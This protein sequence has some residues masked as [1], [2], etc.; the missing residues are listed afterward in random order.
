MVDR[1]DYWGSWR[2]P[3][4][5]L[6]LVLAIVQL[7]GTFGASRGQP[8]RRALDA[9]AILLVLTGPVAIVWLRRYP[10]Q[11][12]W[13][14]ASA[15]LVYLLRGYPFGPVVLSLVV[16]LLTAVVR[17]HRTAAWLAAALVYVGHLALRPLVGD[18]DWSW[19]EALGVGAWTLVILG[20]G[21]IAR[22]R[23]ERAAAA[24]QA[25]AE[26]ERRQVNEERL[27]IAHELH[28]TVAHHMSL[29]NVQAGV[30]LHLV[31]RRPEQAQTALTVIKDASKEALAELRALVGVLRDETEAAPRA[32]AS[33][34][35]SL[36]DVVARSSHAGLTV[37]KRVG[38]DVRPLPAAVELAAFR[39]AQEAVTN[40]VRHS[41]AGNA[42]IML[43]YGADVLTVQVTDDGT[44]GARAGSLVEGSGIR[45]MRERAAALGGTLTLDAAPAGGLRLVATLP[46][47]EGSQ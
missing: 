28:D 33:M 38:G 13:L 16:C 10:V 32:P 27:L 47:A 36:D 19:G 40:V 26:T 23:R 42:D 21:E 17:G 39:I 25:V 44:G 2:V 9:L 22:V 31:D 20:V 46:L 29:I 4:A 34:L 43:D 45:G 35:A 15:T 24:R 12:L 37:R 30:A 8:E 41:G 6:P 14:V 1:A 11:V 3:Y 18:E 5:A 7:G